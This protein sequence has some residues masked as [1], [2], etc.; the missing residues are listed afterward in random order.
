MSRILGKFI[1]DSTVTDLQIRLRN[2]NALRARNAGDTADVSILKVNSSDVIELLGVLNA[3]NFQIKNVADPTDPQDAVNRQYLEG[4]IAGVTDPKE[5]VRA[6]TTAALPAVTYDN[7]TLGDGATLT[8]DANGALPTQDG[9]N[10]QVA[11]RLLVKDQAAGLQNGLYVVTQLGDAG[12]PFILTR[13]EDANSS[14]EVTQGLFTHV[15]EGTTHGGTG[16]LL[17]TQDP[18]TV[19]T[20]A[21][22]FVKFGE[23][24]T[25]GQGIVKSGTTISA[26]LGEG[27]DFNVSDEIAVQVDDTLT[28]GTT[29]IDGSNQVAGRRT[30]EEAFTL[31]GTDI[32]N[33]YVDLTKVASNQ[34]V[35]LYPRFGIKQKDTADFTVS[36]TGGSGGK[37]RVTFAGDLASIIASGDV[38]DIAYESLDY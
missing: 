31:N 34:S 38:I 15:S 25:A 16:F 17:T 18:I 20:T 5:S 22:T 8:A 7:G 2:N 32:S 30:Y 29:K 33:G 26:S 23:V 19:G 35:Q 28:T 27:L 12:N 11:D 13:T 1:Q 4:V 14:A 10:L 24:V 37:T 6:A 36:Y 21:L 9:V 3:G